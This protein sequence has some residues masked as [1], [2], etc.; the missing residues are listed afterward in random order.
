[1]DIRGL[2]DGCQNP[3][4]HPSCRPDHD[5]LDDFHFFSQFFTAESAEHAEKRTQIAELV[6]SFPGRILEPWTP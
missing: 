2:M 1:M 6:K 3:P 4:P 5:R